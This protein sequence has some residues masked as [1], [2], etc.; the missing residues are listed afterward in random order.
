M[1]APGRAFTIEPDPAPFGTVTHRV[2]CHLLI[3]PYVY[4]VGALD[5]CKREKRKA[6][7]RLRR[8]TFRV[9]EG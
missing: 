5:D 7:D 8:G 2:I 1:T 6:E 4:H 9:I 3:S